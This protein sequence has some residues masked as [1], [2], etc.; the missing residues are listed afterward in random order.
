MAGAVA[1]GGAACSAGGLGGTVAAGLAA[2]TVG[3]LSV[4]PSW[5]AASLASLESR[6]EAPMVAAPAVAWHARNAF[7][8][9]GRLRLRA[10]RAPVWLPPSFVATAP[11]PGDPVGGGFPGKRQG[12]DGAAE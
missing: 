8:H 4:P 6:W 2:R 3:T 11:P 1:R 5:T 10:C 12:Y 9:H 7:R